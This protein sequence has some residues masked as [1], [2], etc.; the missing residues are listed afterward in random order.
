MTPRCQVTYQTV[1]ALDALVNSAKISN[2]RER[3]VIKEGATDRRFA[4]DI[5]KGDKRAGQILRSSHAFVRGER[6]DVPFPRTGEV[7]PD[8]AVP[9]DPEGFK[10]F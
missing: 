4:G 5:G 9:L 3:A 2:G 8:D 6:T 1:E 10:D 7:R